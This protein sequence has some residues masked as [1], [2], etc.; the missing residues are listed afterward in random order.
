M[1]NSMP[2]RLIDG[3]LGRRARQTAGSV[4]LVG[5]SAAALVAAQA[6]P[7]LAAPAATSAAS[8]AMTTSLAMQPLSAAQAAQLSQ[9]VTQHV[10]V[11]FK[12]Q[13]RQA[14]AG[15]SAARARAGRIAA[16]Q[17]PLMGE[18]ALVHATH[19]QS[20]TL[21]NSLAATVS[22]GEAARLQADP[23]VQQVI[24]DGPIP[25]PAPAAP[26]AAASSS[27]LKTLPGACLPHGRVQLEPEALQVTNTDS[28][29]PGA[30]T[31]RSLGFTGAGVTVAWMADGIDP[32]NANFLRTPGHAT[33]SAFSD[34]KD[35]SGDGTTAPTAGGE[36]F[37]DANAIAGQGK[38]VYN[39][40]HFSAQSPAKPCKIRIEGVAPGA[41]LVGLKVFGQ[42]NLSTTSGFLDAISYAVNVDHV[43]VLNQ[44]FG[45]SP[46]PD[47]TDA[48]A[49]KQFDEA[50][51]AAG[52][53]V[54]VS[55][56]DAGPFNTIGSP[57]TDPAVISVGASTDFRW[58]AM[59]NYA[60]ADDFARTGWLNNNISSLSSGGFD[61]E[62]GATV[63]LVAPGDLSF[64]SC[65][66]NL[67]EFSDC[68]NF[69]GKPSDIERS[70]GTSQ[71]SPLTA[72]AAALVIQAY[73]KT[74]GG[75]DPSPALVKQILLSTATDLGAPAYEQGAG[76]LN[77]YKAV[78]LA[79]SINGG[80]PAGS[81]LVTST[82]QLNAT[83]YPGRSKSWTVSVT[84][85]GTS[86]QTVRLSG[87]G[88]GPSRVVGLGS[89]TLS[90]AHSKH[91]TDWQGLPNNYGVL[92][93]TVPRGQN[94]LAAEIA[95]PG[96]PGNGNNARV[97]LILIDPR[98]RFAAHS[99]PQGVGNFGNVDV[100]NPVAGRW[101][102]VI[103]S[104]ESGAD[105]GT[106][107][108][109]PFEAS[110]Q[111]YASFGSV[112]PASLS[113]AAGA[114]GTFTV[115][116]STPPRPG[117]ASGSVV[118]NAGHGVTTIPVTLR[119]LINPARGGAFSGTLTGGN[120]RPDFPANGQ[121]QYYEFNVPAGQASLSASVKIASDRT[122]QINGFFINPQG[123]TAGYGSNY[124]AV[125]NPNVFAPSRSMSLNTV[126][127]MPGRW[128]LVVDFNQPVAGDEISEPYRGHVR[129]SSGVGVSS[130]GLPDN[131]S[132]TLAPGSTHTFRVQIHNAGPG[133]ENFF[134]DPRLSGS[135]TVSLL[136]LLPNPITLPI[137]AIGFPQEW[138]VPTES[139]SATVTASGATAPVTFDAGP[140][141]GDPDLFSELPTGGS[142]DPGPLLFSGFGTPVTAGLWFAAPALATID[143]YTGPAPSG[144]TV[145]LNATAQTREF[146][147]TMTSSVGDLWLGSVDATAPFRLY[148]INSGQT[149][150]ITVTIK[151]PASATAGTVVTGD[152]YVDTVV[153][154]IQLAGSETSVIPYAYT[155]G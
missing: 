29:A 52:V 137:P 56:G 66:A 104:I 91:I 75:T 97:R 111:R 47:L 129:F 74:H 105:G 125:N 42:N 86:A 150:A 87:R 155:V 82:G 143:G 32:A 123:Q 128:T 55:T 72:G 109:I 4:L 1:V 112:S 35:F 8:R 70:G 100:V 60:L 133:P 96:N 117:D 38:V 15:T 83:G 11:L 23:A 9:H 48:D 67:A 59:T 134:L 40:Q 89:V 142:N 51:V 132:T 122:N 152:V 50:A 127:P 95:Y 61:Q 25:G 28:T 77:T 153:P 138:L 115:A 94:R 76:L 118:L 68:A 93:F 147:T 84:N 106:A 107:G 130:G 33:T 19:V 90:N 149:R 34:Y 126:N 20:Y 121:I 114:T 17:R 110:T 113:L 103:F 146:D 108:K 148:R 62:T 2:R 41:D 16:Y 140:T 44:S 24:P 27:A 7:A 120:G 145:S 63:D 39:A 36:A 69:I 49:V 53:T 92:H 54:V 119:S 124:L 88:F 144:A 5:A 85:E 58:Y 131:A 78:Q 71:S 10:I 22:A 37:L 141:I 43:N 139:S 101:T 135:E 31:A 46:I 81:T 14:R 21:V 12:N 73:A 154:V 57:A 98:G 65:D 13:P 26:A 116:A 102:A 64:A 30:K 45:S 80:T 18:L 136:P 99:L 151:V 79:E 6:V 3:A